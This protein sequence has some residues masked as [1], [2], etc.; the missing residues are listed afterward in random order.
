MDELEIDD[1]YLIDNE[2][3]I[4]QGPPIRSFPRVR[5]RYRAL[6]CRQSFKPLV[7]EDL[8]TRPSDLA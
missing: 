8:A 7:A 6:G 5:C 3:S 4:A 1:Q 2:I